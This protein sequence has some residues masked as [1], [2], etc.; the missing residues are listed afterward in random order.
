[1]NSSV[2]PITKPSTQP[3]SSQQ[4]TSLLGLSLRTLDNL[5]SDTLVIGIHQ[6]I[7]PLKGAAGFVDWRLCGELSNLIR[8]QSFRGDAGE[9]ILISG[10]GRLPAVRVFLVGWGDSKSSS[11]SLQTRCQQMSVLAQNA[12]CN[13]VAVALPEPCNDFFKEAQLLLCKQLGK[14]LEGLFAPEGTI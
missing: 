14:K 5:S 9:V 2:R 4:T 3:A 11:L 13:Q 1:M 10:R 6:D 7:R 8:N 12:G